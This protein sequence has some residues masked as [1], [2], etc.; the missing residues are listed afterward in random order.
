[1]GRRLNLPV[2]RTIRRYTGGASWRAKPGVRIRPFPP[3]LLWLTA[4]PDTPMKAQLRH[5]FRNPYWKAII[6]GALATARALTFACR[7]IGYDL[8]FCGRYS[9]DAETAQ[10]PGMLADVDI[11]QAPCCKAA[12]K[13][14]CIRPSSVAVGSRFSTPMAAIRSDAWPTSGAT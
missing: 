2:S 11:P 6:V 9:T 14:L 4:T 8:V 3:S 5:P 13:K 1:M 7:R 10:V 12:S